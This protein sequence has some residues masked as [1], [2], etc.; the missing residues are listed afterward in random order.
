RV[1]YTGLGQSRP[2]ENKERF[3]KP[4]CYSGTAAWHSDEFIEYLKARDQGLK[5]GPV[6]I[7]VFWF[8]SVIVCF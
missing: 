3:V 4:K 2:A 5:I 8:I 7:C 6:V 1:V